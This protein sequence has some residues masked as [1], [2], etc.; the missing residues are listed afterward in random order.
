M[1]FSYDGASV[2]RNSI[3]SMDASD[4]GGVAG[5]SLLS[6]LASGCPDS[7]ELDTVGNRIIDPMTQIQQALLPLFCSAPLLRRDVAYITREACQ[8]LRV[9]RGFSFLLNVLFMQPKVS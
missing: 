2:F 1:A 7:I 9:F 8:M 3:S 6:Q 5:R 4:S